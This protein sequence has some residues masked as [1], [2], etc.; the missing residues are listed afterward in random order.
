MICILVHRIGGFGQMNKDNHIC[1]QRSKWQFSINL[2]NTS[3]FYKFPFAIAHIMWKKLSKLQLFCTP[4]IFEVWTAGNFDPA[5]LVP[6]SIEIL[7]TTATAIVFFFVDHTE[8]STSRPLGVW[9]IVGRM[10]GEAE[11]VTVDDEGEEEEEASDD[12]LQV[13]ILTRLGLLLSQFWNDGAHK[14]IGLSCFHAL[15]LWLTDNLGNV[16]NPCSLPKV[17]KI[18]GSMININITIKIL[19]RLLRST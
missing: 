3:K 17:Q 15:V 5:G 8:A 7:T 2:T 19:S 18:W 1:F 4:A 10:V 9:D 11:V 6:P 13:T 16:S 12:D 14:C